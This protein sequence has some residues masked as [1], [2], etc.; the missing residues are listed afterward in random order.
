ISSAVNLIIHQAR[1][2]DGVRR[3]THITEIVG[4]EGDIITLQDLFLFD[5]T[6]GIDDEGR[7]RGQLK[8]TGLRPRFVERLAEHGIA[9]AAEIFAPTPGGRAA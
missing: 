5:Y 2:K 8:A 4:M 3:L 7:F 6:A 9:M 1:M